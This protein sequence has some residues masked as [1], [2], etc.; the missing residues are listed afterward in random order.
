MGARDIDPADQVRLA[1]ISGRKGE[2]LEVRA[3]LWTSN[4]SMPAIFA[5]YRGLLR[6]PNRRPLCCRVGAS[7][8][9]AAGLVDESKVE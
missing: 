7:G 8:N 1:S 9:V 5:V 2:F 6:G 3:L 4:C